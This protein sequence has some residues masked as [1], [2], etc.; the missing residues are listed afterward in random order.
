MNKRRSQ[1]PNRM[2][3]VMQGDGNDCCV[4]AVA[5]V[6]DI[7]L[8]VARLLFAKHG[9]R[10]RSQKEMIM[11]LRRGGVVYVKRTLSAIPEGRRVE[12]VEA[13]P[14]RT[15]IWVSTEREGLRHALVKFRNGWADPLTGR[16]S[17]KLTCVPT[18]ALLPSSD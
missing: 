11:A 5:I 16:V 6:L 12:H 18:S 13:L 1:L 10:L 8:E 4:A 14:R 2:K 3:V 7:G 9:V 17:K 15:I